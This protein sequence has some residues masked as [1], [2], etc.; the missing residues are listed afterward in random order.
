[1]I[2]Q[3]VFVCSR[4]LDKSDSQIIFVGCI[5]LAAKKS[6]VKKSVE[7]EH[8]APA[9]ICTAIAIKW[10]F[11]VNYEIFV[12]FVLYIYLASLYGPQSKP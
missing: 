5:V 9:P 4:N 11:D 7:G 8:F 12:C 2:Q 10:S 3:T 1:M 6:F